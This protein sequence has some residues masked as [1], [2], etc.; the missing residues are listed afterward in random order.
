MD[1]TI[2]TR[3]YLILLIKH[4]QRGIGSTEEDNSDISSITDVE[5]DDNSIDTSIALTSLK[6]T[7][8]GIIDSN[9]LGEIEE[10][11]QVLGVDDVLDIG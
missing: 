1:Y 4:H 8:V 6:T 3:N 5:E 10:L 7:P 9:D 2:K 11:L